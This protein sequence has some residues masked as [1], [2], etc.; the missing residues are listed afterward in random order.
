[1]LSAPKAHD[2]EYRSFSCF[3][4][5]LSEGGVS[6]RVPRPV[7]VGAKLELVIKSTKPRR[8]AWH[9]GRV[10][11]ASRQEGES[12][13]LLGVQFMSSPEQAIEAWQEMLREKFAFAAKNGAR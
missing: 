7:P 5:D 4:G 2:L 9:V 10:V 1:V 12:N 11:W 8:R 6:L 13:H 3:T